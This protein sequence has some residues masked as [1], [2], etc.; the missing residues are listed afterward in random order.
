[1][2]KQQ[3]EKKCSTCMQTKPL[4]EFYLSRYFGKNC[5]QASCKACKKELSTKYYHN[6]RTVSRPT[7]EEPTVRI[8]I[9]AIQMEPLY[10]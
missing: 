8:R 7:R 9:D 4:E 5:R 1:M 3:E 6:V 10:V 2:F